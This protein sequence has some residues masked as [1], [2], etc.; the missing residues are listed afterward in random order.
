[1]EAMASSTY[2]GPGMGRVKVRCGN[3]RCNTEQYAHTEYTKT[4]GGWKCRE[5][6]C[7]RVHATIDAYRA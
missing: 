7:G 4:M 6:S 1:M 3:N 2:T 5:S